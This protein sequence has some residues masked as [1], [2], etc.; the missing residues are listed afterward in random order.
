[1]MDET[2][3]ALTNYYAS[4]D[5]DNRLAS[6]HG[7]VEFLTTMRYVDKY[8]RPGMTVLEIGAATG[9][10]SHAL[11][12][13]GFT[14]TAVELVEHNLQILRANTQPGENLTSHLGNALELSMLA[15]D[16]FDVTLLLGPMY[17]LYND[18]DAKQALAEALRVTKPGGTLLAAYCCADASIY[19]FGFCGGN[20]DVLF[21]KKLLLPETYWVTS[22]PEALFMLYRRED[23]DRLERDLPAA[24]LHY[25]ATDLMAGF[26]REAIDAM[27]DRRFAQYMDYHY[28]LCERPDMAGV[29]N[30]SL[31]V[32]R[33]ERSS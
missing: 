23:I 33:K 5:E 17:H 3:T 19:Q 1:M 26:L 10:Y 20:I 12:R 6:R 24:R 28:F 30:H 7:Q 25:L 15:E 13:R 29:T 31:S 4:Y 2:L 11:A 18:A 9:R 27:D 8:L 22:N 32:L 14:V 16:S 21:E